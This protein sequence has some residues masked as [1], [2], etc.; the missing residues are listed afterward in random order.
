M[1]DDFSKTLRQTQFEISA[2][3]LDQ[4]PVE[5]GLEVA[6]AGRSNAG[7]SSILNTLTDHSGLARTS[8]TPGRTQ[9]INFFRVSEAWCLVDL[10]GY[11]YAK[12]P[13]KM[14]QAWQANMGEYL[15]K[16]KCLA[17]LFLI[18]DIRHP[19]KAFDQMMLEWSQHYQLPVHILLNKSDKLNRNQLNK[20]LFSVKKAIKPFGDSISVQTFSALNRQGLD[21]ARQKLADWFGFDA[22]IVIMDD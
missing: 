10:P 9:L 13:E 1:I 18:M 15:E 4:C 17:G 3:R 8:K 6:F 2:A 19:M 21:E 22:G 7:K 16:R 20:T 14:K 11:G 12:V 5:R